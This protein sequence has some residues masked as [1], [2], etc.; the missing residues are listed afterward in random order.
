MR[1][2]DDVATGAGGPRKLT[3]AGR[4]APGGTAS[5]VLLEE[6]AEPVLMHWS[7]RLVPHFK[8]DCPYCQEDAEEPKPLWYVGAAERTAERVLVELTERCFQAAQAAARRL[9]VSG[10]DPDLFGAP[11]T[12]P[13]VFTGL[14]VTISRGAGRSPRVLRCEQRVQV[15]AGAW[16]Y[17]TR[18]ELA[19][20]WGVP[21]KP[22]LYREGEAG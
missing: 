17:R 10:K 5:Y 20:I 19:R 12:G 6:P 3:I 4:P 22:R 15:A 2:A 9:E 11:V 18:E 7:G 14:L 16:P 13:A 1:Y 8:R 21:M